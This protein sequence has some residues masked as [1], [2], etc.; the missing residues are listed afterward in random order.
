MCLWESLSV[1]IIFIALGS[2]PEEGHPEAPQKHAAPVNTAQW[3][4]AMHV[5]ITEQAVKLT[6]T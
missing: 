4:Q 3:V 5:N 6:T 2:S 1:I